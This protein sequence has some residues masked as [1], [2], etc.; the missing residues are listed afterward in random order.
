LAKRWPLDIRWN[1][2]P[3]HPEVDMEQVVALP[4]VEQVLAVGFDPL[5]PP[6]VQPAGAVAEPAL[7]RSDFDRPAKVR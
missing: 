2:L 7:G 5:E 4:P 3:L 1:E 6:P